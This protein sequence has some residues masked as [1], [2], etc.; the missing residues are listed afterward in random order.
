MRRDLSDRAG[1]DSFKQTV[2]DDLIRHNATCQS[3]V[4][5]FDFL[6]H[7]AITDDK[8]PGGISDDYLDLVHFRPPVGLRLLRR[9]LGTGTKDDGLGVELTGPKPALR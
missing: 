3:R 6:N 5:L 4:A 8:L 9:M 2:L 7:N 1:L